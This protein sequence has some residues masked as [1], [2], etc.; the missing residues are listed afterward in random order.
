MFGCGGNRDQNKRAKMGKIA[1]FFS[2]KI[3][4]TDDN[5]RL[6]KPSKIRKDIKK[7]IKKQKVFEYPNRAKAISEA[8]KHLNTGKFYL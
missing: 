1:D 2:D 5:P 8:I 4:L 6:E 3:Y 7:G